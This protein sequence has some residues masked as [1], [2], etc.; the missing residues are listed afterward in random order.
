MKCYGNEVDN[1]ILLKQRKQNYVKIALLNV[2]LN[3]P[4]KEIEPLKLAGVYKNNLD[5]HKICGM[6]FKI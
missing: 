1:R 2:R 6:G 3:T 4:D 5:L